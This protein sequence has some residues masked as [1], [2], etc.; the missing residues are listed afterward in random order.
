M[1]RGR[2]PVPTPA[3]KA[4]GGY[5]KDRHGDRPDV[6]EPAELPPCPPWVRRDIAKR[7]DEIGG[8]L[9]GL[10]STRHTIGLALLIDALADWLKWSDL[11]D[12]PKAKLMVL[13]Q[14]TRAWDHLMKAC[15]EFGCTPSAVAAVRPA[16]KPNAAEKKKDEA[17][18]QLRIAV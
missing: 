7:W 3:L 4:N 18:P 9:A 16:A 5:R 10:M 11:A 15:R 8:M 14:K 12:K 13:N 1:K 6:D 2:R 17:P